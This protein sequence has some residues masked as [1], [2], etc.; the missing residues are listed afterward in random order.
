[1]KVT[2]PLEMRGEVDIFLFP[3]LHSALCR[4]LWTH[5]PWITECDIFSEIYDQQLSDFDFCV[6]NFGWGRGVE[7]GESKTD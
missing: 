1:M 3:I 2:F 5:C 6:I 7:E 4:C